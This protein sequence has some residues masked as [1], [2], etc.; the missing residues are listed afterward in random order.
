MKISLSQ[1]MAGGWFHDVPE[2][3]ITGTMPS[4]S[5]SRNIYIFQASLKESRFLQ[6]FIAS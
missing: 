2:V 1:N 5:V 3:D 6:P 4:L